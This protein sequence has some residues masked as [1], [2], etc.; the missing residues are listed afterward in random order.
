MWS[1]AWNHGILIPE[2]KNKQTNKKHR[3]SKPTESR[4]QKGKSV[5]YERAGNPLDASLLRK[6]ED[7]K[8]GWPRC[9]AKDPWACSQSSATGRWWASTLRIAS[10]TRNRC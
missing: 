6:R 2:L 10:P 1:E 8:E 7:L 9:S 3:K 4:I 5:S